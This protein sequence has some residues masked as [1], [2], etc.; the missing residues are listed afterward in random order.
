MRKFRCLDLV[1]SELVDQ[2]LRFQQIGQLAPPCPKKTI[3]TSNQ[4]C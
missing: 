1:E 2:L 4:L 3:D